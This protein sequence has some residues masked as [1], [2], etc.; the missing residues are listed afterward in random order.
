MYYVEKGSVKLFKTNNDGKELIVNIVHEREFFGHA[1]LIRN[2]PYMENAE[3]LENS[4]IATIPKKEFDE[5]LVQHPEATITFLKLLANEVMHK[6]EQLVKIA[7]NSLRR[8]VADALLTVFESSPDRAHINI[9]RDNLAAVAGTATESLI[10]TLTDFKSEK[11]ID[12]A[13]GKIFIL[14]R[15]RLERMLN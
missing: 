15:D 12:I 10:R 2:S 7:Y 1:A 9:S 13:D 6:E 14:N 3:A 5:L 4:E 8:K 11:L